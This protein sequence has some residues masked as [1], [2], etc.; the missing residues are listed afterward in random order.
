MG[1]YRVEF[2]ND[3]GD[4][5]KADFYPTRETAET[6]AINVSESGWTSRIVH[7]GKILK[8]FERVAK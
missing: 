8:Y 1:P 4:W 2:K 3:R 7:N 6:A 5:I